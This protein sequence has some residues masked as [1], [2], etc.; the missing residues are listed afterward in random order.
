[1]RLLKRVKFTIHIQLNFKSVQQ[2]D[3]EI[4]RWYHHENIDVLLAG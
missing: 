1:M 2:I 3:L 4:W